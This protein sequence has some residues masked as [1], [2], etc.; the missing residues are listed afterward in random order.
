MYIC[1]K[2][3]RPKFSFIKSTSVVVF[4]EVVGLDP[5]LCG[6]FVHCFDTDVDNQVKNGD[7]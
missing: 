6:H 2:T 1:A 5:I 7:R 4:D 3:V